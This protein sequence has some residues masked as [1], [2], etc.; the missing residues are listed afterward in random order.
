M[1]GERRQPFLRSRDNAARVSNEELF[2]DLVYVFSVTQLSH[3]FLDH[4][5]LL[6]AVQT[7]VMW[8]AVWL[9]WQYTAWTTNWFDPGALATRGALFAIMLLA[10]VM[11]SALPEAFGERGL[12]FAGCFAAI[13]VGRTVC[14]L[15]AAGKGS[16]LVPNFRRILAWN[17]VAAVFWIA[18][19]FA[20]GELRLALWFIGVMAEYVSPMF[21]LAF[22]GLGR[23]STSEWTIDGGHLAERCQLFVIVALGESIL[24]S[25]VAFGHHHAWHLEELLAFFVAFLGSLAMWWMYFDTSS[26]DATHVIEHSKDPGAIGAQFH[27][28]HV[29]LVAGIIVSAVADE[30]VIADGSHHA[31][32]NQIGALL[33]GPA[34]YLFG[35]A[36]FKRVVYGFAPQSHMGGLVLLA[37]LVFAAPH[38]TVFAVGSLTT[39]V[40]VG[41][42]VFE[43]VV[44]RKWKEHQRAVPR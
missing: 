1:P 25:G 9:G 6:G 40:M 18:G 15:L 26:K 38:L 10:L 19:G 17:C 13:Q 39:L 41:V 33:G 3:Y 8:F 28:T 27:Y 37:L 22:P 30:L 36:L 12:V 24:A 20:H 14:M 31:Q 2:F 29:I 23:S 43:A 44:R 11:A 42:A 4:L 5:T 7:L 34:I 16:P 32:W 35:N 21:G